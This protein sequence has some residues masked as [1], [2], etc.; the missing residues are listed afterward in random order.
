MANGKR[1]TTSVPGRVRRL[2]HRRGGNTTRLLPDVAVKR[3]PVYLRAL[4]EMQAS[5]QEIVSSAELAL[6]TGL[7][8]E[9]IRK[10]LAMLG[11]FGT[12]GVGY[13]LD[14]L[15]ASI[16]AV[17]GLDQQIPVALVGAGH[18]GTA[19]AR[20]NQSR[21]QQPRIVVAFD[22]D[23]SKVGQRVGGAVVHTMD[24]LPTVIAALGVRMAI[25]TV[26]VV[27]A[28]SV[29]DQLAAAGCDVVLNFA[30]VRLTVP[31]R[32]RLHNVDLAMELEAMAYYVRAEIPVTPGP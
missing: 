18:L 12:R 29:V 32:V 21:H 28:Q 27:A 8:S 24:E 31:E 4:G 26:P 14:T 19:L 5:G 10:D 25:I 23:P 15:A 30:P 3:L 13:R 20:Y 9:Q 11:G 2:S 17:L 6:H 16:R 7:T 1:G 22:V